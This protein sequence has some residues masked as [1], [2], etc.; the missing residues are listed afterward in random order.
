MV[1]RTSL[2]SLWFIAYFLIT[3]SDSIAESGKQGAFRVGAIV[4]LTGPL[5]D[6][7]VAVQSG[8]EFAKRDHPEKFGN[9]EIVLQDS[10]YDGMTALNAFNTLSARGDVDLYYVRG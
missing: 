10:K 1:I 8:F 7:G 6:Y 4:P 5:A 3:A 2:V 9:I